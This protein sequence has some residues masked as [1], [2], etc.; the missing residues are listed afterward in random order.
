MPY[1]LRIS[2]ISHRPIV[3][4]QVG[5]K[6]SAQM[7]FRPEPGSSRHTIE[8]FQKTLMPMDTKTSYVFV[9]KLILRLSPEI[10]GCPYKFP[11]TTYYP[12]SCQESE[13]ALFLFLAPGRIL[14]LTS[15]LLTSLDI[16]PSLLIL[17]E[18]PYSLY[19]GG[20]VVASIDYYTGTLGAYF[21]WLGP[22]ATSCWS[23]VL[24]N[25]FQTVSQGVQLRTDRPRIIAWRTHRIAPFWILIIECSGWSSMSQWER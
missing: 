19:V 16:F 6:T 22:D 1:A 18:L 3:C 24:R 7:R 20:V 13:R 4:R 9:W 21:F 11:S 8:R 2:G 12:S 5:S 25:A 17:H 10:P 23:Q 14:H 15:Y